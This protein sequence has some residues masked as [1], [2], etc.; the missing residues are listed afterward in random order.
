MDKVTGFYEI[1]VGESTTLGNLLSKIPGLSGYMERGRR[2]EAELSFRAEA[3][4][5]L[6]DAEFAISKLEETIEALRDRNRRFDV[7]SPTNGAV[8]KLFVSNID[9]V[10]K[11]GQT[12]AEI[13]ADDAPIEIEAKLS[14]TD[15]AKVWPGLPAL[16]KV[17]AYDF[18]I[19]GGLSGKV[20][21]VS[22]DALQDEAGNVFFRVRIEADVDG[23][24]EDKP[25]IPGMLAQVDILTGK[26]TILQYLLT[27]IE[28]VRLNALRE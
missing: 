17:S 19:H 13:V 7:V 21:E 4:R 27:P 2:R 9:A 24:G 16:V 26:K 23:L 10:V 14:P 15:R 3:Q 25:V 8:N 20:V 6:T 22:A 11:P 5:Q 18:A 28:Q 12:I 1:I